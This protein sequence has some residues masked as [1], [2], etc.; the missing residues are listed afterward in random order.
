MKQKII[1]F[2]VGVLFVVSSIF[3]VYYH[4]YLQT[5]GVVHTD[6]MLMPISL[7]LAKP[8]F[9]FGLGHFVIALLL[10]CNKVQV[11]DLLGNVGSLLGIAIYAI[12]IILLLWSISNNTSFPFYP[13]SLTLFVHPQWFLLPG[14]LLSL[15]RKRKE[16]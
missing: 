14:G 4:F 9:F 11:P 5:Q 2:I 7:F 12:Y 16:A 8:T 10:R 13:Y 6:G 3:L 1:F 15:G